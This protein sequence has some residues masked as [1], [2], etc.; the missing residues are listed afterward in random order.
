VLGEVPLDTQGSHRGGQDDPAAHVWH[1]GDAETRRRPSPRPGGP[2]EALRHPERPGLRHRLVARHGNRHRQRQHRSQLHPHRYV[3]LGL[4]KF[5][6]I[7]SRMSYCIMIVPLSLLSVL[8]ADRTR[9][10]ASLREG[11]T[12]PTPRT[13]RFDTTN[14]FINV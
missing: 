8:R 11:L 1:H 10:R 2:Q 4:R 12:R 5:T 9:S 7:R 3:P 6:C 14:K 13:R